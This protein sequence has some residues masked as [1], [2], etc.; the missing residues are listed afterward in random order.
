MVT[1]F[2]FSPQYGVRSAHDFI[3]SILFEKKS[4]DCISERIESIHEEKLP[5]GNFSLFCIS[6]R[7][8]SRVSLI[9][10]YSLLLLFVVACVIISCAIERSLE[11]PLKRTLSGVIV[12]ISACSALT[13]P[14]RSNPLNDR[15]AF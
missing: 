1:F 15:T 3:L 6:S 13:G 2:F 12:H 9:E 10:N 11:R 5:I 4:A 7:R 8:R 14:T